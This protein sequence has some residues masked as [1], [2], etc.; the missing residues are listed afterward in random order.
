MPYFTLLPWEWKKKLNK[1]KTGW[2][3]CHTC[4]NMICIFFSV[5]CAFFLSYS[6]MQKCTKVTQFLFLYLFASIIIFLC[7][8][9]RKWVALWW[10]WLFLSPF[11]LLLFLSHFFSFLFINKNKKN[12][13]KFSLNLLLLLFG[14]KKMNFHKMKKQLFLF[15]ILIF[16]TQT[17]T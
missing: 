8:L 1:H 6:K 2:L 7:C 4:S 3:S 5:L 14:M 16:K 9:M 10:S 13:V 11:F 12:N 17:H 15:S